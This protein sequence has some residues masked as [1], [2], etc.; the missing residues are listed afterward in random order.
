ME[1]GI[2][3]IEILF[4]LGFSLHNIEEAIWLPAWSNY[5]S[6]YHQ[7]VTANQFNFAV[8]VITAIGFLV[9]FQYFLWGRGYE[10]SKFIYVGFVF[11]MVGNVVFPHL[12]ATILLKKYAPGLVT[13]LLLN[14]PFGSYIIYKNIYTENDFILLIVS[15]LLFSAFTL[16]ILKPLFSLSDK[17]FDFS[18]EK[19]SR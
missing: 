15:G 1:G 9:T 7:S 6:R 5:A 17:L 19:T 4:L 11:M 18:I 13:G 2:P 16:L 3:R 8:I 10:I 12:V 14:A